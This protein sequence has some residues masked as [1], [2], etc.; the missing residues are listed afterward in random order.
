MPLSRRR[1]NQTLLATLGATLL[2]LGSTSANLVE[3]RDWRPVSP[4]QPGSNPEKIEILEFFSYGCPHCGDLNPIIKP[5]AEALPDDVVFKRIPVSFGRAAWANLAR[6]FL[7]LEYSGDLERLDQAVFTAL[8]RDRVKLFT[9]KEIFN[10]LAAQQVNLDEFKPL[11][12]SFAVET[13]LKRGD[14][15]VERFGVTAVPTIAIDGRFIVTGGR[16]FAEQL[17]IASDLINLARDN[18]LAAS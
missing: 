13:Q 6:L 1:F 11:F 12:S 17:A 5:W 18:A 10:W 3:G 9:E 15:M 4:P 7:A 14:S 16:T 8:H 2:P